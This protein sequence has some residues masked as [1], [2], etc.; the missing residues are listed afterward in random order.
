MDLMNK[1]IQKFIIIEEL[2]ESIDYVNIFQITP[3]VNNLILTLATLRETEGL[4]DFTDVVAHIKH[5]IIELQIYQ[6]MLPEGKEWE[7]VHI[8]NVIETLYYDI[9]KINQSIF[10]TDISEMMENLDL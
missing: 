3:Y 9:K 1:N 8:E 7:W 10:S 2:F 6:K 4:Y 5:L